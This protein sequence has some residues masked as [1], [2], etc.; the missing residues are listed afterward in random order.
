VIEGAE[1][2]FN[3]I[4]ADNDGVLSE[5]EIEAGPQRP[6]KNRLSM[7]DLPLTADEAQ[8]KL[9]ETFA[10]MDADGNGEVTMAERAAYREAQLA[11]AG[12]APKA[13]TL[14]DFTEKGM[15]P[16][17]LVDTN[18]DGVVS[19]EEAAAMEALK[20]QMAEGRGGRSFGKGGKKGG[21]GDGMG[22]GKG[23]R[24]G[25]GGG[26]VKAFLGEDGLTAGMTWDDVQAKVTE[27]F[28]GL[29]ADASGGLSRDE[30]R[31]VME[32]LRGQRGNR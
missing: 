23:G 4:D 10:A 3:L 9:A 16:F 28:N 7:D 29:D 24:G 1:R 26:L 19:E 5:A 31:P 20:G 30:I 15:R 17:N 12:V 13:M 6:G 32:A 27:A 14:E 2:M 21:K 18:D 22:R 8:A 11:E 25:K